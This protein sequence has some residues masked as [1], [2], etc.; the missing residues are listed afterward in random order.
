MPH[1]RSDSPNLPIGIF[2]AEIARLLQKPHKNRV[3]AS[4]LVRLYFSSLPHVHFQRLRFVPV[5]H[6][7]EQRSID[8]EK[9]VGGLRALHISGNFNHDIGS[10]ILQRFRKRHPLYIFAR[11]YK[12]ARTELFIRACSCNGTVSVIGEGNAVN[13]GL[14]I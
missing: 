11:T 1:I 10:V 12:P 8:I 13:P 4:D 6:L 14:E 5:Q 9:S 2:S 3:S 7:S